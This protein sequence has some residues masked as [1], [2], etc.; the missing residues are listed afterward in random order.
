M[1]NDEEI[2]G[3]V[4]AAA[5]VGT[6]EPVAGTADVVVAALHQYFHEAVASFPLAP[7]PVPGCKT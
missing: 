2:D 7:S 5:D 3:S 6:A 4:V 1:K